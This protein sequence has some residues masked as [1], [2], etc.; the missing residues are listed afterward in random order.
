[1]I[2][3]SIVRIA[4]HLL[5]FDSR[6][7]RLS[8][9]GVTKRTSE[10]KIK[11]LWN[12]MGVEEI[13]LSIKASGFFTNEPLIAI[14]ED[15]LCLYF[16]S[17]TL[18]IHCPSAKWSMRLAGFMAPA[19]TPVVWLIGIWLMSGNLNYNIPL[20]QWLFPGCAILFLIF[21]NMHTFIV[22]YRIH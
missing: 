1:M 13:V 19:V 5:S 3:S 22:F 11:I 17:W 12:V 15:G 14:K 18:L 21:H 4:T 16:T 20:K 7:P 9:F 10:K 2:N 6:D 8:E